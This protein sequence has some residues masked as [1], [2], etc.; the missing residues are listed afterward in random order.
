MIA[1]AQLPFHPLGALAR[2]PRGLTGIFAR[3]RKS[4]NDQGVAA[5]DRLSREFY[6]QMA[7]MTPWKR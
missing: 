4:A 3:L 7:S 1:L 5:E 6:K 2:R